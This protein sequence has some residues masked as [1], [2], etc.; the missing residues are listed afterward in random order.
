MIIMII[1]YTNNNSNNNKVK[2]QMSPRLT[3]SK[4]ILKAVGAKIS[5]CLITILPDCEV[6]TKIIQR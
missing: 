3:M 6:V 4:A 2:K 1:K 5:S